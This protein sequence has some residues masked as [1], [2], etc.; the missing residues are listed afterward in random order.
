MRPWACHGKV[1]KAG[2]LVTGT[3]SLGQAIRASQARRQRVQ[4]TWIII[5]SGAIHED[6][7]DAIMMET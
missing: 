3:S 2:V 6:V 1:E 5:L 7:L 4:T